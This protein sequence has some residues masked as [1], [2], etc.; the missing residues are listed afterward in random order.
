MILTKQH[1]ME[2]YSMTE[3]EVDREV[4]RI[5]NAKRHARLFILNKPSEQD[6]IDTLVALAKVPYYWVHAV[7]QHVSC[8]KGPIRDV[9]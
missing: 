4:E 8:N 3:A 1:L 6:R 5:K 2:Y 9:S 7:G